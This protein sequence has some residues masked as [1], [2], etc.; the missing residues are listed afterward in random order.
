MK[1]I[2]VTILLGF[3]SFFNII[4]A[5]TW[6]KI[7]S[8]L[9]PNLYLASNMTNVSVQTM[10]LIDQLDILFYVLCIF[11]AVAAIVWFIIGSHDEEPETYSTFRE[12]RF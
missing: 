5:I 12:R 9:R 7:W 3:I 8:V 2:A 6:S 11:F 10:P 4:V 1:Y